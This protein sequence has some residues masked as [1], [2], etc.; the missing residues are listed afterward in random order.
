[1]PYNCQHLDPP[2]FS[3]P[4]TFKKVHLFEELTGKLQGLHELL[5]RGELLLCTALNHE[6]GCSHLLP[7]IPKSLLR[8]YRLEIQSVMF[9]PLTFYLVSSLP[10][11]PLP[12]V[13]KYTVYTY[14]V[15]KGGIGFL[16]G[17]G[18]SDR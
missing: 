12:C 14:T 15:G 3:L 6:V 10:S 1:M 17:E 5:D 8:V 4:T 18:A 13:N 7:L 16:G 2:N 11:P 9:A